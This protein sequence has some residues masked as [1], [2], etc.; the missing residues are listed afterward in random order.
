MAVSVY[1]NTSAMRT[2]SMLTTETQN[3]AR[4]ERAYESGSSKESTGMGMDKVSI[5]KVTL[6]TSRAVN[7]TAKIEKSAG[8]LYSKNRI[9][10]DMHDYI[11]MIKDNMQE[12]YSEDDSCIG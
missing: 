6:E 2:Q 8:C 12:Q 10:P 3:I 9:I 7:G 11:Q 1:G 4:S 5:S